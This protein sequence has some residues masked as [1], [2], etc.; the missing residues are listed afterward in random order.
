MASA[1]ATRSFVLGQMARDS[2]RISL[3]SQAV[4]AVDRPTLL[5]SFEPITA[6][7][8]LYHGREGRGTIHAW[9]QE[10]VVRQI[11]EGDGPL[12]GL[13]QRGF[14]SRHLQILGKAILGGKVHRHPHLKSPRTFEYA[15][16]FKRGVSVAAEIQRKAVEG[17]TRCCD[18]CQA[19][20]GPWDRRCAKSYR[21]PHGHYV[22]NW[23]VRARNQA[24]VV[25]RTTFKKRTRDR[26]DRDW[27][28]CPHGDAKYGGY[29]RGGC[30]E[31][32][33]ELTRVASTSTSM[34]SHEY[35]V[36]QRNLPAPGQQALT[37]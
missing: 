35:K 32:T 23:A 12:V 2:Q 19:P 37:T 17:L 27:D 20:P 10:E 15:E 1:T 22:K 18:F 30:V 28:L 8:V 7:V 25:D 21:E 29:G 33:V 5:A 26:R 31:A 13:A 16:Q 11:K 36:R 4:P 34:H 9:P 14:V 24:K 6:D 3:I